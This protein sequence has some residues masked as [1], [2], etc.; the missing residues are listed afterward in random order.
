MAA[1]ARI[2]DPSDHGGSIVSGSSTRTVDGKQCA[3][4]GDMHSCPRPGHGTTPITSG[5]PSTSVDGRAIARVGSGVGCG[6]V[7]SA[8]SPTYST[9]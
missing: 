8:G 6:A 9:D 2:G 4:V 1:V 7:I 3:R 5:S